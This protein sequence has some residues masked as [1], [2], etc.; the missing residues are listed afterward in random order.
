MQDKIKFNNVEIKQPDVY[1]ASLST[2][3]T[4]DSVRDMAM[5][6][7]NTPIGTVVGYDLGW[8]DLTAEEMKSILSQVVNK[9]SVNVH[10]FDVLTGTWK[11]DL[12]YATTFNAP[13]LSLEDGVEIWDELTFKIVGV[14]PK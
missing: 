7:H 8:S 10:Y 13:A 12:F 2:T 9:S 5:Q 11:D 3:S 4:D 1:K 14:N 6:M